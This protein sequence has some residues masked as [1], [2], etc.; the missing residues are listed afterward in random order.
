MSSDIG[1]AAALGLVQGL[2]LAVITVLLVYVY[3][4]ISSW[5][6]KRWHEKYKNYSEDELIELKNDLA[7]AAH[8]RKITRWVIIGFISI[9]F[10][11]MANVLWGTPG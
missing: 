11:I 6:Q 8:K 2:I 5:K 7:Q 10:I 1:G 3:K 4:R 9:T